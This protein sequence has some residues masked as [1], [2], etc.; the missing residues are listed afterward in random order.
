MDNIIEVTPNALLQLKTALANEKDSNVGIRI[1][2]K[3]GGC[4]GMEW[5]LDIEDSPTKTDLLFDHDGVKI[6]IDPM[7]ALYLSGTKLDYLETLM[8]SGF[9]FSNDKVTRTC[10]CN[11]S[12]SF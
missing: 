12:I 1:G 2:L 10:G 3:G 7:S 9:A 5:V 11:K 4:V 8:A 6:Y